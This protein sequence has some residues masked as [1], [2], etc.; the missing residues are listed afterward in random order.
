[1]IDVRVLLKD[2]FEQLAARWTN[3]FGC[4]KCFFWLPFEVSLVP[5]IAMVGVGSAASVIRPSGLP[6][7]LYQ[8]HC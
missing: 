5:W 6:D 8:I 4:T 1:M 3:R 2:L 7:L